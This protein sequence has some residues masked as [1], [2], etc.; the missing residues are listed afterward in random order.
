MKYFLID[1]RQKEHPKSMAYDRLKKKG[2]KIVGICIGY[3]L[4]LAVQPFET[5]WS[6]TDCYLSMGIGILSVIA[7][8]VLILRKGVISFSKI[9]IFVCLWFLYVILRAYCDNTYPSGNF[10]LRTIQ[11]FALYMATRLLFSTFNMS[12]HVLVVC[13][14]ICTYYEV[15]VGIC[16]LLS[17]SSRH[18]IY[19]LSG[20]FMNPGPYSAFLVI[21]LVITCKLQK[22]YWSPTVFGIM[23]AF[24]CSRAALVSAA[25]C[26]GIIYWDK[27]KHRKLQVLMGMVII[28]VGLYYLKK[29]SAD[30]R[31]IIYIISLLCI[32]ENPIFG[33][34]IS[35]FC[36]QYAEG[37]ASFS[38]QHPTFNFISADVTSNA[39]NCLL[40]IGIEQGLIGLCLALALVGM[41]F[42]RLNHKGKLLGMSLLSLFIFSMFSYPFGQLSYQILFV[43]IAAFSGTNEE[44]LDYSTKLRKI[45]FNYPAPVVLLTC[46]IFFSVFTHWQINKRIMAE[47]NYQKVAG[48]NDVALIDD[49][50]EL[51]PLLN[52]NEH[53][54]FEFGKLLAANCRYK[55]SNAILNLGTRIS[56][57]PMFYVIQGNN[58][59][60]MESFEKAESAYQKAFAIMPNRLYPLY[61]LM[62]LYEKEGNEEKMVNMA[63]QVVSFTEKVVSPVTKDMKKEADKILIKAN[64]SH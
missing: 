58:Y 23:L 28:M 4:W 36:H 46:T 47:S 52:T 26:M 13:I 50:F 57:D 12:E 48:I 42:E 22:N 40:Q 37:M 20:S 30:G 56:C 17:G 35:S 44:I 61:K 63:Q 41:M 21:G 49:Y 8:F 7:S 54:L 53:Y 31:S 18:P 24:S 60:E 14:L 5:G 19:A 32:C 10:C 1:L 43:L 11:M 34:G 55:E 27:W 25:V 59:C 29:G 38:L 16:Q 2:N 64:N 15:F 39:Y 51:L 6:N 62:L 9:D 33:S 3:I 45:T